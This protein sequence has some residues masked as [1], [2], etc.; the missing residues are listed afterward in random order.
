[1]GCLSSKEEVVSADPKAMTKEQE[2]NMHRQAAIA[3]ATERKDAQHA[4]FGHGAGF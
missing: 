2:R 3:L 4:M 1:M